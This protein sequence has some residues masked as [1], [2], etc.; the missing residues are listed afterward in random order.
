MSRGWAIGLLL[1]GGCSY[2]MTYVGS[3]LTP[4]RL[5]E[6]PGGPVVVIGEQAWVA[7]AACRPSGG[8]RGGGV[9][10]AAGTS[11]VNGGST[12][13]AQTTSGGGAAVQSTASGGSAPLTA[14]ASG[15]GAPPES[16]ASGG[17]QATP[18]AVSGGGAPPATRVSGG[19]APPSS[20]LPPDKLPSCRAWSGRGFTVD[21]QGVR[22]WNGLTLV[23]APDGNVPVN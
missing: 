9:V 2:P 1:A 23:A 10:I 13:S 5:A 16:T 7:P 14:T 15:G 20:D 17:G 18:S 8:A 21:A 4:E 3:R 22:Y 12:S 11:T 6:V 19:G